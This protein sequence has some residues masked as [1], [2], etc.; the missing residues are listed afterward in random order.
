MTARLPSLGV[1]TE[2]LVRIIK[3]SGVNV[4]STT[5]ELARILNGGLESR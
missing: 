3:H 2:S 5:R 1:G 4:I